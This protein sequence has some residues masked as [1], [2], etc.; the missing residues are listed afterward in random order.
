MMTITL[1]DSQVENLKEFLEIELI[2]SIRQ[3]P[4]CDNIDYLVDM[5]DIYKILKG[6]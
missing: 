2:P 3:N 5:C 1:T 6:D 4:D